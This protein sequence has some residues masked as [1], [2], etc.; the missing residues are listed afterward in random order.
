[1]G[2]PVVQGPS[3]GA[4]T[5]ANNTSGANEQNAPLVPAGNNDHP[6]II[7]VEVLGH[8][9]AAGDDEPNRHDDQRGKRRDRQTYDP[10]SSI[11]Y[12]GVGPLT[13]EQKQQL[14]PEEQQNLSL[15]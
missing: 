2:L 7:I 6:S 10:S 5:A 12:V 3:V 9:G 15:H 13:D 4:L 8:G 1:V 11:R 14:T